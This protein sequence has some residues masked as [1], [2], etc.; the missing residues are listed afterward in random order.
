M[1]YK[2]MF[3]HLVV[4]IYQPKP[5]DVIFNGHVGLTEQLFS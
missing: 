1:L 3:R 5:F 2:I 4:K